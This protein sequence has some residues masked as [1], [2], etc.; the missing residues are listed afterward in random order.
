MVVLL[1]NVNLL[2]LFRWH[3]TFI[4]LPVHSV[5]WFQVVGGNACCVVAS[6]SALCTA[7]VGGMGEQQQYTAKERPGGAVPNAPGMTPHGCLKGFGSLFTQVQKFVSR[8]MGGKVP[9]WST[10][11]DFRQNGFTQL[12]T[13]PLTPS[14]KEQ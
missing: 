7:C 8:K 2:G 1:C 6:S 11:N 3:H 5:S 9:V 14:Q 4:S 10:R 13:P 12:F